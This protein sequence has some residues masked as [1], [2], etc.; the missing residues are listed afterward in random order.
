MNNNGVFI[1][2]LAIDDFSLG[3]D[4]YLAATCAISL[5]N[6]TSAVDDAARR[7]IR[8]RQMLHEL[9]NRNIR[10]IEHGDGGVNDLRN[11]VWWNVGCHSHCNA[12]TSIDEQVR[13]S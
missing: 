3:T 13:D 8:P 1:G 7:E 9:L 11:I 10:L 6:A 4:I 12:G 2:F 5:F